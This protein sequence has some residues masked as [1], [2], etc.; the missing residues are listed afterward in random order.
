MDKILENTGLFL[1]YFQQ[2]V[3]NESPLAIFAIILAVIALIPLYLYVH[4]R[5]FLKPRLEISI[6]SKELPSGK[7]IEVEKMGRCQLGISNKT[8]HRILVRDLAVAFNPTMIQINPSSNYRGSFKQGF[9]S[10]LESDS[11]RDFINEL[12]FSVEETLGKKTTIYQWPLDYKISETI[13]VVKI[14][15]IVRTQIDETDLGFFFD[16]I[17][18]KLYRI[19]DIW[20]LKVH[21]NEEK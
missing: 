1:S 8:K 14:K 11:D 2:T 12:V 19:T 7:I 17:P 4:T 3:L 18:P 13:K 21:E 5:L 10:D 15:M 16:F 6:A 9:R 20:K